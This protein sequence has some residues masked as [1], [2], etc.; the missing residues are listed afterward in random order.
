[1]NMLPVHASAF[2]SPKSVDDPKR[3][4]RIGGAIAIFFFVILLGWAA[5]AP[6]YAGVHATGMVAVSGN[7]QSV[8]HREGGVVSAIHVREGQRVR[9]GE[10]LIELSTPDLKAA[11]RALT[12]DYLTLLAQR[13]R[14][15][16]ETRGQSE[17]AAPPEFSN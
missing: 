12:S 5:L 14:L 8:Q 7:R 15:A 13:A 6:L 2:D 9:A 1:M 16:A 11:E 4:V 3:D 10:L 17:F